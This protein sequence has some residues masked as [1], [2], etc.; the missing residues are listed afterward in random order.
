MGKTQSY[1]RGTASLNLKLKAMIFKLLEVV[2]QDPTYS[3]GGN[4]KLYIG[5]SSTDQP[6]SMHRSHHGGSRN[7]QCW[8]KERRPLARSVARSG[9]R[10]KHDWR[11]R[12]YFSAPDTKV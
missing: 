2:S 9:T 8:L 7:S 1:Q 3:G 11:W 6:Y 4:C 12:K 10:S 5:P